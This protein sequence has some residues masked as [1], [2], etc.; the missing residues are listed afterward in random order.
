MKYMWR[1]MWYDLRHG[2]KY[3][4]TYIFIFM[5]EFAVLFFLAAFKD[6]MP[7]AMIECF[8]IVF[9]V[10]LAWAAPLQM[11]K[12]MHL[13][14][15]DRREKRQYLM[16]YY[17]L[18]F[19]VCLGISALTQLA[20]LAAGLQSLPFAG[21][22]LFLQAVYALAVLSANLPGESQGNTQ[23]SGRENLGRGTGG[24]RPLKKENVGI[25][26]LLFMM[27]VRL[28]LFQDIQQALWERKTP[29]GFECGAAAVMAG[30]VLVV[31]VVYIA[32][33]LPRTLVSCSDY[34]SSCE[35]FRVE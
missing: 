11:D 6:N 34:E 25:L 20:M 22:E 33:V 14:P 35:Y 24:C 4:Y 10:L 16:R 21:L 27:A 2:W 13:C 15:M 5:E 19:G 18:R 29:N 8:V 12:A 3:S 26:I 23:G 32:R 31:A 7:A 9:I 28:I 17:W 1:K 30:I